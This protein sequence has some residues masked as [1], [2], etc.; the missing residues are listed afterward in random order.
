M[1]ESGLQVGKTRYTHSSIASHLVWTPKYRR[2]ILTGEIQK[3][4]KRLRE[5]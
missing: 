5:E 1:T 4:T 3:E 2:R